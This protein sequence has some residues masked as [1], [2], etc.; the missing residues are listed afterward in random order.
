MNAAKELSILKSLGS[1]NK[2]FYKFEESEWRRL[3]NLKR[4]LDGLERE[5]DRAIK[6]GTLKI[7]KKNKIFDIKINIK[8]IGYRRRSYLKIFL[9]DY[10]KKN[11][12][13]TQYLG[14]EGHAK[15]GFVD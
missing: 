13:I 9:M 6:E 2:N 8:K 15:K 1:R 11:S 4:R 10:F 7:V 14:R 12:T 3:L 5:M